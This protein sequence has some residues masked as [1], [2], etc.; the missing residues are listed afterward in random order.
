[1]RRTIRCSRHA[2]HPRHAQAGFTLFELIVAMTI[3][4]VVALIGAAAL[5]TISDFYAR[6]TL[7][8]AALEDVRATER[9]LRHEWASRGLH[10]ASDGSFLEFDTLSPASTTKPMQAA[11]V[12]YTCRE[13]A[14]GRLQ[15]F[16]ELRAIS[17]Q[18]DLSDSAGDEAVLATGLSSCEFSVLSWRSSAQGSIEGE[19]MSRW[20]RGQPA[21]RLVRLHLAGPHGDL[22]PVVYSALRGAAAP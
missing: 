14:N 3:S 7:R 21:P 19:W 1:M 13:A 9:I 20:P 4:S 17:P 2:A 12:R 10:A 16:H 5:S 8:A 18:G 15:L 22:P 6:G 11:R